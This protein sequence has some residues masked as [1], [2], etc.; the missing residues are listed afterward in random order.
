MK[1]KITA[2]VKH[3]YRQAEVVEIDNN[4]DELQ[5]IVGG[6]IEAVNLPN[7]RNVTGFVNDEG[8]LIGLEPNIYRPEFKD[9]FVGPIVFVG[10]GKNG[11]SVSLTDGQI[12]NITNYLKANSVKNFTDFLINIET[13]F[14]HYR[15]NVQTEM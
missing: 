9:A 14:A 11:D 4:L 2:M 10:D 8:L 12:K 1:N 7:V 15:P 3:P 6:Y 5:Q 13:D